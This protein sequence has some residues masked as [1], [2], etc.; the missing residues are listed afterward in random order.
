MKKG[1]VYKN[2]QGEKVLIELYDKQLKSLNVEYED[3][4][5]QTRFGQ[6]H[7]LKMGNPNG[8]PVLIFHGGNNTTPYSLLF[9]GFKMLFEDFC[10]YAVDTIG[11]PGKSAQTILSAKSLEYGEW[12][13]DVIDG[14]G[15]QKMVCIGGSFGGGI[16]VKLMCVAPE[17]IEKAILLVPSGIANVSTFNLLMKMGI[18]MMFYILTK[19]DYWLKKAVLPMAIDEN[20]IDADTYEMV[21]ASFKHVHVKAG[22]PSNV[23]TE[24]LEKC[25]APT[26]VIGAEKDCMFPGK[27]VIERA[28]KILPNVKTHLLLNQGHMFKL[29]VD[30]M[31]MIKTFINE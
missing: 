21:K 22:M 16:L 26:L 2:E 19:R 14:L 29:S 23:K 11:H 9:T 28:E 15:F 4:Y 12:A 31:N 17:K 1:N 24:Q 6:S 8:K 18:P 5:V 27:K 10:I 30:D 25:N 13:S 7:V 20:N 3:L